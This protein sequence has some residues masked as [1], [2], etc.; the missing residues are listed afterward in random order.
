MAAGTKVLAFQSEYYVPFS[1]R[2]SGKIMI[3]LVL[4]IMIFLVLKNKNSLGVEIMYQLIA[5]RVTMSLLGAQGL[6][7]TRCLNSLL[8]AVLYR[9]VEV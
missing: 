8:H 6:K 3:F 2:L 1:F 7:Q 4:K 5:R 9:E